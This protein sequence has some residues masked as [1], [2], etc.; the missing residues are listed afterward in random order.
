[1]NKNYV[2]ENIRIYRE[3]KNITQRELGDRIGKTWE[4]ISRYE[5]GVS[6]PLNQINTLADALNI[7]IKDL[8]KN[9]TEKDITVHDFNRIPFFSSIPENSDFRKAKSFLYYTAPDWILDIDRECFVIAT[10]LVLVKTEKI[11]DG[12]LFISP[13]SNCL[14]GDIVLIKEKDEL[15]VDE[16]KG[17]KE[18]IGKILAQEIAFGDR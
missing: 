12:K 9:P 15:I 1:M 18:I 7:D 16:L 11:S 4:M 3:R 14:E 6:S 2:G 10:D 8:F 13:N 5:R 17:N